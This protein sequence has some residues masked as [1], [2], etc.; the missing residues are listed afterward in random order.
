MGLPSNERVVLELEGNIVIIPI[1]D[2]K[3]S[4][5]IPLKEFMKSIEQSREEDLRLE[6]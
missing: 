4:R 3:S 1:K 2:I 6:E 5:N